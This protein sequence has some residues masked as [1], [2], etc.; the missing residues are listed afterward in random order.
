MT[1]AVNTSAMLSDT[2]MMC[3]VAGLCVGW[4]DSAQIVRSDA[5]MLPQA[6]RRQR[7]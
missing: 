2:A 5:G 1:Q 3:V 7:R 6:S 4:K